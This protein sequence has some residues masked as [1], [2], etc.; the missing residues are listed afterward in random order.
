M[1]HPAVDKDVLFQAKGFLNTVSK[2]N[3]VVYIMLVQGKNA[4]FACFSG[5]AYVQ[6]APVKITQH[7]ASTFYRF[8]IIL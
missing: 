2:I 1:N 7:Y 3:H 4:N 5:A 8:I 6:G